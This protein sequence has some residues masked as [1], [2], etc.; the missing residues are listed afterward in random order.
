[1][2]QWNV[3]YYNPNRNK[4]ETFN[5]FEHGSCGFRDGLQIAAKQLKTH[6]EFT[7]EVKSLLM[8]YYWGKC[9]WETLIL[10]WVSDGK[11]RPIKIDVYWQI[12]NAWDA[13]SEYCWAHKEE[14]AV[15]EK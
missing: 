5:I 15:A 11:G 7:A 6:E 3:F 10:P 14:L 4:I 1:M 9:E 13:F 12:I 8:Y 2:I